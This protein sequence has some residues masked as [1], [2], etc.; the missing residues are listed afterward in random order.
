MQQTNVLMRYILKK[1]F[2]LNLAGGLGCFKCTVPAT[3]TGLSASSLIW[4]RIRSSTKRKPMTGGGSCVVGPLGTYNLG[5]HFTPCHCMFVYRANSVTR[6][7]VPG[8]VGEGGQRLKQPP[9]T[10]PQ[11]RHSHSMGFNQPPAQ[12]KLRDQALCGTGLICLAPHGIFQSVCG[13][14]SMFKEGL[15]WK[16][17]ERQA[18]FSL[19][20]NKLP[21]AENIQTFVC[22][23][24]FILQW[25]TYLIRRVWPSA[26]RINLAFTSKLMPCLVHKLRLIISTLSCVIYRT[27]CTL[28]VC[29]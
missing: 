4:H 1:Q 3:V 21:C 16:R 24:I 9:G 27:N 7:V 14:G 25:I 12:L 26:G 11:R 2:F 28:E 29:W 6:S 5:G 18:D 17:M 10:N 13:F 22:K 15:K 8:A 19:A 20:L 23:V